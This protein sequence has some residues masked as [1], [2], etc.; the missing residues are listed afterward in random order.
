[1][2]SKAIVWFRNDL[3]IEDN[4][5]LSRAVE[6]YDEVIGVYCFDPRNYTKTSLG[7]DKTGPFRAKFIIQS[8]DEVKDQL[9]QKGSDLL[10]SLEKPEKII[11]QLCQ[12]YGV[13]NVFF[14]N[15]VGTE[16]REIEAKLETELLKIKVETHRFWGWTL[17]HRDDL[18]F[19]VSQTPDVFSAFRKKL[20]KESDVRKSIAAPES[21]HG[22]ENLP[23][24]HIPSLFQLGFEEF[25]EDDR[26][27]F[28]FKGGEAAGISHLKSYIW[29]NELIKTYKETR[30]GLLGADY[31]SKFSPWLSVGALSPR[32]IFEEVKKYEEEKIKNKSTYWLV[33]ELIWRDFFSIQGLKLGPVLFNIDGPKGLK[34]RWLHDEGLFE[35]WKEGKTGIPFIDANMI[36]LKKTGFMSNRGRQNVASFLTKDLNINWLWGAAYFESMLIDHDVCSNYGNWQY[37]AGVG[38]DP[39]EDRY[40]NVLKQALTY[41]QKAQYIKRWIPE[42]SPLSDYEAHR[43]FNINHKRKS[44]VGIDYPQS[45]K[46]PK[47]FS[48]Y[49]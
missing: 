26:T 4:E 41:D 12:T 7:L 5:A 19:P 44:E 37:V 48:S 2:N 30:N 32:V 15:E 16:E 40:F 39:R 24:T 3:R 1:M 25:I 34:K 29:E 20:E 36:E 22:F 23:E 31:S 43:V 21:M 42:L 9:K 11:P 47:A 14:H 10:I 8:V 49:L 13:K 18:P 27:A 28:P 17:Y 46:V 38:A 6:S 33:F 35:Q 45:I